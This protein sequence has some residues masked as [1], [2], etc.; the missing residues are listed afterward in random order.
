[1]SDKRINIWANGVVP[2][3]LTNN[4]DCPMS[5]RENKWVPHWRS[6]AS[7]PTSS[8]P[9]PVESSAPE[10]PSSWDGPTE[11]NR[12]EWWATQYSPHA[13]TQNFHQLIVRVMREKCNTE[14]QWQAGKFCQSFAVELFLP[15][16]LKSI[17]IVSPP[18]WCAAPF[19]SIEGSRV[20]PIG[21]RGKRG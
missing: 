2:P 20:V 16:M 8:Y 21:A 1:M 9:N 4:S 14:R 19:R 6:L 12:R 18:P 15:A 5:F 10:W 17:P 3:F 7:N 11:G 13:E